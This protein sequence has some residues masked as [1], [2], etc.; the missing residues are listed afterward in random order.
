MFHILLYNETNC[1][2]KLKQVSGTH[3]VLIYG[4]LI[5]IVNKLDHCVSLR[6]NW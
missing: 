4:M 6:I 3:R 1:L 2:V 5:D